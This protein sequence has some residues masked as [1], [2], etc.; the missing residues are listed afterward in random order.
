[1]TT[2]TSSLHNTDIQQHFFKL[3][4]FPLTENN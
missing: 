4:Q 1:M 2:C 3:D